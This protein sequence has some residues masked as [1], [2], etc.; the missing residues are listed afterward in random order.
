[1]HPTILIHRD[2]HHM[3]DPL[4]AILREDLKVVIEKNVREQLPS[5][6]QGREHAWFIDAVTDHFVSRPSMPS[7]T[8]H[9]NPELAVVSPGSKGES[10]SR[11]LAG[12]L[13]IPRTR[14]RRPGSPPLHCGVPTRRRRDLPYEDVLCVPL[15]KGGNRNPLDL[16]E[17]SA[18]A[19][20]PIGP[21]HFVTCTLET[22]FER[23]HS[24]RRRERGTRLR[25]C[26]RGG[27]PEPAQRNTSCPGRELNLRYRGV[28]SS[29]RPSDTTELTV[30]P[31]L[32][33]GRSTA[34][35]G[36]SLDCRAP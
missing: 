17:H 1:M 22:H 9:Y 34:D 12:L 4:S 18:H 25:T 31:A 35:R 28:L 29:V 19:L 11:S 20:G 6:P 26:S 23:H 14:M 3:R 16:P 2:S 5:A 8:T 30:H 13:L 10:R 33:F 27:H 21:T 36:Q 24:G 15:I 7:T 32:T